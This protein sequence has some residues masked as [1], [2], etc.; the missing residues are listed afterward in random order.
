[1]VAIVNDLL[2]LSKIEA[3]NEAWKPEPVNLRQVLENSIATCGPQATAKNITIHRDIPPELPPVAGDEQ[4]LHQVFINLI[5]NGV[6]Y[7]EAGWCGL[8]SSEPLLRK[9]WWKS[10]TMESGLLPN[11]FLEFSSGSIE[12][13]RAGLGEWEVRGWVWPS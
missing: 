2:K 7:T 10:P 12:W 1:M 11:T 8:M 9:L 3:S 6:K 13:I 4:M 5:D